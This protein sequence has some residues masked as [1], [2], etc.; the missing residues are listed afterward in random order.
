MARFDD[1]FR[2][3][4]EKQRE[5]QIETEAGRRTIW[6]VTV[7]DEVFIRSFRAEDGV[8]YRS[9][10]ANPTAAIDVAGRKLSVRGFPITGSEENRR[11]DDAYRAK[12]AGSPYVEQMVSPEVVGTTMRL[13]PR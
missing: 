7:G 6:V 8:W 5:I 13:E 9:F 4:L 12:Y 2:G 1:E 11:I 3:N 10:A